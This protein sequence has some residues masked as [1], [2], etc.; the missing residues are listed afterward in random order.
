MGIVFYFELKFL[1]NNT[2]FCR[3][4]CTISVAAFATAV[5]RADLPLFVS[6]QVTSAPS[7]IKSLA[8]PVL[9]A[10]TAKW[11]GVQPINN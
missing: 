9:F 10:L 7:S 11:N 6:V 4:K 2:K 1:Q 5:C 3:S 8:L